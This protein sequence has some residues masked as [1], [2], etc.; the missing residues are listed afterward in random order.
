MRANGSGKRRIAHRDGWDLMQPRWSPDGTHL[1]FTACNLTYPYC[2]IDIVAANAAGL[3][4]VVGGHVFD[5]DPSWSPDGHKIAFTSNRAGLVSAVWTVSLAGRRLTRLTEPSL[6]GFYP[7]WSPQGGRILLS[8]ND[9]RQHSHTYVMRVDGTR[10]RR[11]AG[12]DTGF[13]AW[14][15]DSRHIV[16]AGNAPK[17]NGRYLFTMSARGGALT[18]L[19]KDVPD[20]L[21][22]DWGVHPATSSITSRP[23]K[24]R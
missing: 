24:S 22:S 12:Q 9:E 16:L 10:L 14:A 8:D 20:V 2:D 6:E 4:R 13:A 5:G 3:R 11:I 7:S 19:V 18:P 17:G 15:P 1:A 21:F 23:E